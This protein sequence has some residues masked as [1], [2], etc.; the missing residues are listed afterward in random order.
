MA[1]DF[2]LN[3]TDLE[4]LEIKLHLFA[5][6]CSRQSAHS[7]ITRST[8]A[9]IAVYSAIPTGFIR[10][11][12]QFQLAWKRSS[13]LRQHFDIYAH[14]L[15]RIGRQKGEEVARRLAGARVEGREGRGH[16]GN[17]T[18]EHCHVS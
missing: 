14:C 7:R 15:P 16:G 9:G 12:L 1:V 18:G 5:V 11:E 10:T 2:F 3:V 4:L 17:I 6:L 8:I 13:T